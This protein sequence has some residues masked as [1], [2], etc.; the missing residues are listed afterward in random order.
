M[1][2]FKLLFVIVIFF[3]FLQGQT[4][5]AKWVLSSQKNYNRL[6]EE[7]KELIKSNG[8]DDLKQ[9][10]Q[11][12]I[13]EEF[14]KS[15][16][17]DKT[18]CK[19][20][21]NGDVY[22]YW[23][24]V[25]STSSQARAQ[26]N[27]TECERKEFPGFFYE[28]GDIE[29]DKL[30]G[31]WDN[32]VEEI[33]GYAG[34]VQYSISRG[35][36]YNE[37]S[38]KEDYLITREIDEIFQFGENNSFT[39]TVTMI[40][41]FSQDPNFSEN[42]VNI[43]KNQKVLEY[44]NVTETF[45][46]EGIKSLAEWKNAPKDKRNKLSHRTYARKSMYTTH[47]TASVS[48]K[49]IIPTLT[50]VDI[51]NSKPGYKPVKI[52]FEFDNKSMGSFDIEIFNIYDG[53]YAKLIK[54]YRDTMRLI[55]DDVLMSLDK[56]FNLTDAEIAAAEKEAK[57]IATE[58]EAKRIATE[59][60]AK[61]IATEKE[62]KRIATEKAKAEA[63]RRA[64]MSPEEIA[65]AE[66]EAK[67]IAT[68]KEAKRIA[69]EKEAKR[70]IAEK[71][72]KIAAEK[73]AKRIATEKAKWAS[74]NNRTYL[75]QFVNT[76]FNEQNKGNI[77]DKDLHRK[78]LTFFNQNRSKGSNAPGW[79]TFRKNQDRKAAGISDD[80]YSEI[81]KDLGKRDYEDIIS[82]HIFRTA[83]GQ[84]IWMKLDF[85][86]DNN[87]IYLIQFV[88]TY[89]NEQNKGNISDEDLHDK[90]L[91]FFDKN[92]SKGS[93]APGWE[94]FRKNEDRKAAGISDDRYSEIKKDLGKRDYEDIISDHIFRTAKGQEI[95]M[96]L[97]FPYVKW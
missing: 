5:N 93:N 45:Y 72:R 83:K 21:F 34:L 77:S 70:I 20:V 37:E 30:N 18:N 94:S 53:K 22:D 7:A 44:F 46:G 86:Y 33:G 85:P 9:Q 17:W 23:I 78:L 97:G 92:R 32:F 8:L 38:L 13:Q 50:F 27:K 90:L 40:L 67:R 1:K 3:G 91:V 35:S 75:I 82:D 81:K 87:R 68:E 55:V 62:A 16:Y 11:A 24:S 63:E 14:E 60:E 54:R 39:G 51:S 29:L 52:K 43:G 42:R 65:A 15:T 84:E 49:Y 76:Y 73:E 47:S 28:E 66:K 96:K 26:A 19:T 41:P 69:T 89:F 36:F 58:K 80:R 2:Y 88:N 95:W 10:V 74:K 64:S 4:K 48:G 31:D 12:I 25:G 56:P 71:A 6:T 79:E 61:R 59:K 57:R